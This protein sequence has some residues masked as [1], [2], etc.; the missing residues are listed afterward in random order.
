MIGVFR[1]ALVSSTVAL[2]T[3]LP[4]K[5]YSLPGSV[6]QVSVVTVRSVRRLFPAAEREEQSGVETDRED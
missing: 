1:A 6:S 5:A 2:K 4:K 3:T